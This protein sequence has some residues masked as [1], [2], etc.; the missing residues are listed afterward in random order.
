MLLV[1]GHIH[2]E[3]DS[4]LIPATTP[5]LEADGE[6]AFNA[7]KMFLFDVLGIGGSASPSSSASALTTDI[8]RLNGS[9]ISQS[10]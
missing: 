5:P 10:V 1:R 7:L 9:Q 6:Q 3:W 2:T 4:T 8:V